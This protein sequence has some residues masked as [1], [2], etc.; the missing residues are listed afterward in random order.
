M[1]CLGPYIISQESE[2]LV[3]YLRTLLRP[4]PPPEADLVLR[5]IFLK[6]AV[7]WNGFSVQFFL[8]RIKNKDFNIL[9]PWSKSGRQ[10]GRF[11]LVSVFR[12]YAEWIFY[13]H[14]IL[15]LVALVMVSFLS[16]L[17]YI[18]LVNLYEIFQNYW[19]MLLINSQ[20]GLVVEM[21]KK[22]WL[23]LPSL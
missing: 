11:H 10:R 2:V 1:D 14:N 7:A 3:D 8:R 17:K 20:C 5:Q 22:N 4:P 19:R 21:V 6:G 12:E 13:S 23:T 9:R 16:L 15:F 18:D